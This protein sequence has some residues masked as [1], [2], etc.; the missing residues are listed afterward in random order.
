MAGNPGGLALSGFIRPEIRR[1]AI[2]WAEPSAA[3]LVVLTGLIVLLRGIARY[4]LV[5]ELVGLAILL[6]GLA[7]FWAGLRRAQ[8]RLHGA[9]GPGLV[10]V[11]EQQ[12]SYLTAEGGAS[13]ELQMMSRLEI[14]HS[15]GLGRVWVLHQSGA[16]TLYIPVSAK[17]TGA[18]F[19]AFA[20]LP[21]IDT[22]RLIAALNSNAERRLVIWRRSGEI[23]ALT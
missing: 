4:N 6:L 11:T 21:G 17:G 14:R 20:A 9:D 1:L 13:V 19:D 16:P 12:I 18:L 3:S 7:A 22:Q 5:A 23:R 10:E 2:R 15:I 8:F